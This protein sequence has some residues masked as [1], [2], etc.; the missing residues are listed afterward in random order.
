MFLLLRYCG[1]CVI[2]VAVVIV[3][4]SCCVCLCFATLSFVM[5]NLPDTEHGLGLREGLLP[6]PVDVIVVVV[7]VVVVVVSLLLSQHQIARTACV[8]GVLAHNAICRIESIRNREYC[9][10]MQ[11]RRADNSYALKVMYEMRTHAKIHVGKHGPICE[12][13]GTLSYVQP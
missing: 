7:V 3:V 12:T 1:C 4:V 10:N 8:S 6:M 11:N 9:T 13:N 5:L 2:V